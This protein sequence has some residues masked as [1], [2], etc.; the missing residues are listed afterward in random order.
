MM[1]HS[2]ENM[3][4]KCGKEIAP[5]LP[6]IMCLCLEYICYDPNYNYDDSEDGEDMELD[7][8]VQNE[9]Q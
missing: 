3:V 6:T 9:V 7:D 2:G 8:E 4:Y 1:F 5:F